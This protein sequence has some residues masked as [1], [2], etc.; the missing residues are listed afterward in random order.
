MNGIIEIV[1]LLFGKDIEK[2]FIFSQVWNKEKMLSSQEEL[3]LSPSD[4]C[5]DTL[6]LS[7]GDYGERGLL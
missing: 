4:L 5:S 6:P 1:N 2:G 3:N 7:H